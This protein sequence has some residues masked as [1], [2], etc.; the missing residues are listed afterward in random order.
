MWGP[1]L[2]RVLHCLS[3]TGVAQPAE[4]PERNRC[5]WQLIDELPFVLP[6]R[7]CRQSC[8]NFYARNATL[9]TARAADDPAQ[10]LFALHN[11]VKQKKGEQPFEAIH[12]RRIARVHHAAGNK[13]TDQDVKLVMFFMAACGDAVSE[14]D[15]RQRHCQ[16]VRKFIAAL[17]QLAP[18]AMPTTVLPEHASVLQAVAAAYGVALQQ[19]IAVCEAAVRDGVLPRPTG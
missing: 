1:P 2:W 3:V 11:L 4:R 6:C 13:V 16:H 8:K 10:F 15:Q 9:A 12:F 18:D 7:E 19:V 5:L 17:A 14:P